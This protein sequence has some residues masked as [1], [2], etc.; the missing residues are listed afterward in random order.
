MGTN[1]SS[2]KR[3]N[4]ETNQNN[5]MK[6]TCHPDHF[7]LPGRVILFMLSKLQIHRDDPLV[8]CGEGSLHEY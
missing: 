5:L 2:K 3:I 6:M 1:V 7:D 8:I 4:I